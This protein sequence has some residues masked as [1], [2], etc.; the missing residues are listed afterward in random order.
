V[1]QNVSG[2]KRDQKEPGQRQNGDSGRQK[3]QQYPLGAIDV[4][5]AKVALADQQ[6][7]EE[8]G[9]HEKERHPEAVDEVQDEI[10]KVRRRRVGPQRQTCRWF[11][12]V[13]LAAVQ[14]DPQHHHGAAQRIQT[15][16][17]S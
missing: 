16:V 2:Q 17:P 9:E 1:C 8:S 4:R 14:H 11:C 13:K 6:G 12:H 7:R 5:A 10:E 15:V 3:R